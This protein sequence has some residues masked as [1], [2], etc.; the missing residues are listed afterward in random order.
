[1]SYINTLPV[2]FV[3]RAKRIL[4]LVKRLRPD[5]LTECHDILF[6]CTNTYK[7]YIRF[8]RLQLLTH[9]YLK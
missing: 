3:D 6:E 9:K 1:M 8:Y 4:S 7:A 2:L 5:T